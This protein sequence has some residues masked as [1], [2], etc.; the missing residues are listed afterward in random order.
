M[1]KIDK[2]MHEYRMSGA[3]WMYDFIRHNSMGEA[4]KELKVRGAVFLPMEIDSHYLDN[5]V[6]K[7]KLNTIDTVLLMSCAVLRDEFGFGTKRMND[8]IERF[9]LKTDCLVND[10]LTWNDQIEILK[11]ETGIDFSIRENK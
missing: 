11:E 3:K 2:K 6:E 9:K 10:M 4:E 5:T 7:I 8:F 1:A